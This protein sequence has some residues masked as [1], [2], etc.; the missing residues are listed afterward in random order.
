MSLD[1]PLEFDSEGQP[2]EA[3]Y[4]TITNFNAG[5]CDEC[6]AM[7]TLVEFTLWTE[8][9]GQPEEVKSWLECSECAWSSET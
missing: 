2:I 5:D 1:N 3:G 8:Q 9:R 6:I 7:N 4:V